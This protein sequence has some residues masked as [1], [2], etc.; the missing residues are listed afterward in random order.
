MCKEE[1]GGHLRLPS[2]TLA[3]VGQSS[4]FLLESGSTEPLGLR[5]TLASIF[6]VS[7]LVSFCSLPVER[8]EQR[9]CRQSYRSGSE[10]PPCAWVPAVGTGVL[11]PLS[12]SC[13][14]RDG[15]RGTRCHAGPEDSEHGQ[16]REGTGAGWEAQTSGQG[17][18]GLRFQAHRPRPR[19]REG[20][21]Y[22]RSSPTLFLPVPR[23]P[24]PEKG[25]ACTASPDPGLEHSLLRV[26]PWGGESGGV[27]GHWSKTLVKQLHFYETRFPYLENK[28]AGDDV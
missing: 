13:A 28:D 4:G 25:P 6:M 26:G 19:H 12:C 14:T 16:S 9:D 17:M 5:K 11:R 27:Q 23:A 21:I 2:H 7:M 10:A 8:E 22:G 3:T 18:P 15:P 1:G 20:V 24:F